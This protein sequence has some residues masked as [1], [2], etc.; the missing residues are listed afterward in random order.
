MSHMV[1]SDFQQW[2]REANNSRETLLAHVAN[3]CII[4]LQKHQIYGGKSKEENTTT[5]LHPKKQA[6]DLV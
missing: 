5:A 1:H 4:P 6:T 3:T 2:F